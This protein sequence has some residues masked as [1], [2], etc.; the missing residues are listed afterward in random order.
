VK[1]YIGHG[2]YR[3]ADG[4]QGWANPE[5]V[6]N[7]MRLNQRYPAVKGSIFFS[8]KNVM[9]NPLG[10]RDRLLKEFYKDPALPPEL[11]LRP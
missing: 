7:Q 6:P 5:E 8:A 2:V 11:H 4:T 10:F 9:A 3:I 1:C